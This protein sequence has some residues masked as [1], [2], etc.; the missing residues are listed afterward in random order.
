MVL[1]LFFFLTIKCFQWVSLPQ[2]SLEST[3]DQVSLLSTIVESTLFTHFI[4]FQQK[5]NIY[6]SWQ[7]KWHHWSLL[8]TLNLL[9]SWKTHKRELGNAVTLESETILWNDNKSC[10][11][12]SAWGASPPLFTKPGSDY[13]YYWFSGDN[14]VFIS[15]LP[16]VVYSRD[17]VRLPPYLEYNLGGLWLRSRIP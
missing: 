13:C 5:A 6:L 17:L 1:S 11:A 7:R 16:F 9:L 12:W 3:R 10:G 2:R 8:Q 4:M 14:C 15:R